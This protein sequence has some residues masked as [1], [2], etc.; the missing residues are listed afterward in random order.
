MLEIKNLCKS[1]GKK[2]VIKNISLKVEKGETVSLLGSNGCGKSTTFKM[3]ACITAC[4]HGQI[5]FNGEEIDYR[6]VAY[7]P[8]QRS[9]FTDCTVYEQ[10]KLIADLNRLDNAESKI[11]R[12][13]DYFKIREYH[14]HKI[15]ILSKGNQ[16]KVALAACLLKESELILLDEP[17]TGL[18]SSNVDIFMRA[19]KALKYH[20]KTVLLSSHLYQPVNSLCDRYLYL[21]NGKIKY[22]IT[23]KELFADSRRVLEVEESV[24]LNGVGILTNYVIGNRKRYIV[25]SE[26]SAIL[27]ISKLDCEYTYRKLIFEDMLYLN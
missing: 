2:E 5:L 12:Q 17:F 11:N 8:E 3:L 15:G 22:D 18:D 21:V 24:C 9:L 14:D 23:K 13:M 6:L 7:L 1:Y 10:L 16:Q 26:L 20:K 4:D 25:D 19:I 27:L